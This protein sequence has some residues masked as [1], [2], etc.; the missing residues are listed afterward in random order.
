VILVQLVL[1]DQ[2]DLL[3]LRVLLDLL[4]PLDLRVQTVMMGQ[5]VR[6]DPRDHKAPPAQRGR[7]DPEAQQAQ[8]DLLVQVVVREQ[9]QGSAHQLQAPALLLSHQVAPILLRCSPS[10]FQQVPQVRQDQQDPLVHRDPLVQQVATEVMV[11]TAVQVRP[12]LLG[13]QDL[14]VQQVPQQDSVHLP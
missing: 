9:P 12:D 13:R 8:L 7:R 3:G 14:P 1:V 10:L 4:V 6:Q 5:T 11:V 2:P